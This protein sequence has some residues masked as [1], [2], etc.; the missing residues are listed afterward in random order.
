VKIVAPSM[1]SLDFSQLDEQMKL[2][3]QSKA[4]WLHFDVMDGHFVPNLTFGPDILKG[5]RKM[6]SLV[7]DVHLMVTDPAFFA[8]IF[9]EAGADIITFHIEAVPSHKE[10]LNLIQFIKDKNVKVGLTIKPGTPVEFLEP[11]VD[12]V[13]M[14]LV[15]S[16][17]PGFGGQKFMESSI[18]K[19]QY[20]RSMIE[21]KG[22]NTLIEVD[23]G[24][25]RETGLLV[26]EAGADILVA[27]SYIFSQN[28][29]EAIES[30]C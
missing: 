11:Y 12:K 13:D 20:L 3:N 21:E 27:G 23:G 14:I 29:K 8:P 17:N 30:L 7:L 10:I 9:I 28:I 4:Q 18:N 26:R 24:I 16:V 5:I 25:N 22:C 2:L 15:M 6:T 1:L 19:I